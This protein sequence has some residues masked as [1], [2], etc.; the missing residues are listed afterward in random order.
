MAPTNESTKIR[1]FQPIPFP[2]GK[3][4][5]DFEEFTAPSGSCASCILKRHMGFPE[6]ALC[7]SMGDHS[8]TCCEQCINDLIIAREHS[9]LYTKLWC[10]I[11]CAEHRKKL[12]PY[13]D[14]ILHKAMTRTQRLCHEDKY[15]NQNHRSGVNAATIVD[16]VNEWV[17]KSF[18]DEHCIRCIWI[19]LENTG[20]E[21]TA[22]SKLTEIERRLYDPVSVAK[23]GGIG[24]N[25]TPK[26][27]E[28]YSAAEMA[29]HSPV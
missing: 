19:A 28:A 17:A 29:K 7:Q 23:A 5:D 15:H 25:L 13:A 8:K 4:R 11:P 24:Y 22:G 2:K 20:K 26:E 21:D 10:I 18:V 12:Q 1:V 3:S 9:K 6:H 27:L 14:N 16:T